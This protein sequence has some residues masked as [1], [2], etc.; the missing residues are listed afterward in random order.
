MVIPPKVIFCVGVKDTAPPLET[1]PS[2]IKLNT[3]PL[4]GELP[5]ATHWASDTMANRITASSAGKILVQSFVLAFISIVSHF[6]AR[7]TP[8]S[9]HVCARIGHIW[10]IPVCRLLISFFTEKEGEWEYFNS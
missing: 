9:M 10:D 8:P 5:N 3:V 4:V 1:L 6:G 7:E 2:A